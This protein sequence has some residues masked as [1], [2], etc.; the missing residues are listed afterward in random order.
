MNESNSISI[1]PYLDIIHRHRISSLCILA[2]GLVLTLVLV[3]FYPDRYQSTAVLIVRSSEVSR[4]YVT[5]NLSGR[6]QAR[7]HA[8]AELVLSQDQLSNVIEQYNLYPRARANRETMTDI[9]QTMRK[10]IVID[11]SSGTRA[12]RQPNQQGQ[13]FSISFSYTSPSIAQ[14]VTAKLADTFI[15]DDLQSRIRDATATT[16]FITDQVAQIGAKLT[17]KG[18]QLKDLQSK[19]SGSLPGDLQTNL[20]AV[21]DLESQLRHDS[22]SVAELQQK[23]MEI[24]SERVQASQQDITITTPSGNQTSGSPEALLSDMQTRLTRMSAQYSDSYPDVIALKEQIAALKKEVKDRQEHPQKYES[25]MERQ[26][27][28]DGAAI[29]VR[30]AN[31]QRELAALKSQLKNLNLAIAETPAHAQMLA[32]VQRDYQVLSA[33]YHDLLAKKLAAQ[34]AESLEQRQEGE[35]LDVLDP[36]S[37]P[38][39]PQQPDRLTAGI[40]GVLFSGLLA[41]AMPFM[42]FFTDTSFKD[43]DEVRNEHGLPVA[44]TI[45]LVGMIESESSSR[46][47]R[48]RALAISSACMLAGTGVIWFAA[49]KG[50]L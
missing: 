13:S 43:P 48:I 4:D 36:A 3:I 35:R 20:Q 25:P 26:L 27:S 50:I 12:P 44:A 37:L 18:Q 9:V 17:A 29:A 10:R 47:L 6:L 32:S 42:L 2:V 31:R 1:A 40:G 21:A 28:R 19:F 33:T 46:A 45:P 22:D 24:E 11:T 14:Q 15:N 8:L 49:L 16:Q 23:Q 41:L 34:M 5:N 30:I 39:D 38:T 7:L